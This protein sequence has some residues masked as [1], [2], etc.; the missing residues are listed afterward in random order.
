MRRLLAMFCATT[1]FVGCASKQTGN[2][3]GAPAG[4]PQPSSDSWEAAL[5]KARSECHFRLGSRRDIQ[6]YVAARV[7]GLQ[8]DS[9]QVRLSPR[10]LVAVIGPDLLNAY[11]QDYGCIARSLHPD[12]D[13]GL[14]NM[15]NQLFARF[16]ANV[17][18]I[19]S[20][21]MISIPNRPGR[22]D[23]LREAHLTQ[24]TRGTFV[25]SP[26]SPSVPSRVVNAALPPPPPFTAEQISAD[27][28]TS[29][30]N[31][32]FDY[33]T[34]I[35]EFITAADLNAVNAIR[36]RIAYYL[37]GRVTDKGLSDGLISQLYI[38]GMSHVQAVPMGTVP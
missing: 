16:V 7:T 32:G 2:A 8:Q 35:P 26:L 37:E 28:K 22:L 30:G 19:G 14:V 9:L 3:S 5:T 38:A 34:A 4:S 18:R 36:T 15:E 1:L 25:G 20:D 11:A 10:T 23:S 6:A 24:L 33:A 17:R 27:I 21:T 31:A 29:L 13:Q 12:A